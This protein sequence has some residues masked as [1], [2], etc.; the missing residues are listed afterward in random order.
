MSTLHTRWQ[1]W[2]T[3]A[4]QKRTARQ[5]LPSE[6]TDA[7][8]VIPSELLGSPVFQENLVQGLPI[9]QRPKQ[10]AR[11]LLHRPS[12]Q[13]VV[14]LSTLTYS[15]K[16]RALRL[17]PILPGEPSPVAT[18]GQT[19]ASGTT[20]WR[21]PLCRRPFLT[22]RQD[23]LLSPL[24]CYAWYQQLPTLLDKGRQKLFLPPRFH[25]AYQRFC[26]IPAG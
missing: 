1:T 18:Q 16:I 6:N 22:E 11:S 17:Q 4:R 26:G 15:Q 13:T 23:L 24:W 2:F 5:M 14:A 12:Q 20:N 3:P 10:I 21:C 7:S 25:R 19:G 8:E 9:A